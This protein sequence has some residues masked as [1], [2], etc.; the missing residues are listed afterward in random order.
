MEDDSKMTLTERM[1]ASVNRDLL[2]SLDDLAA[3]GLGRMAVRRLVERGQL[4]S[5]AHGVY[6][7]P[8][9]EPHVLDEMAVVAKRC[10]EA[11]FNLYSAARF[12]EITQAV[13]PGIWI[14]LPP[15]RRHP[16]QM[17]GNFLLEVVPLRWKRDVDVEVGIETV[18]LRGVELRF[19]DPSRT[20]VDM[21]RYSS[22]NQSLRGGHS[23]IHDENLLQCMGAYLERTDGSARQLADTARKLDL[24]AAA[25]DEFIRFCRNFSGGFS[26]AHTF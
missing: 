13:T 16:P 18:P 12:H 11:V 23:R 15:H 6:Q 14:G 7:H 8:D 24:G 19:T 17:G 9:S 26:Y 2:Y 5:P 1:L 25:Y 22:H 4:D 20:V 10:P 21:W 3:I